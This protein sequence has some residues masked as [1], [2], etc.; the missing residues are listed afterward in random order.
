M[1]SGSHSYLVCVPFAESGFVDGGEGNTQLFRRAK[2]IHIYT[3]LQDLNYPAGVQNI[4][5]QC[6][7]ACFIK[8][9]KKHLLIFKIYISF[10]KTT[11][12]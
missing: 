2:C 9:M 8:G 1:D 12:F 10:L 6:L 3:Y 4:W 7:F 11:A 5:I